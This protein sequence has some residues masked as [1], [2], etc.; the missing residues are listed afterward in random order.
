MN[1]MKLNTPFNIFCC[2]CKVQRGANRVQISLGAFSE[3]DHGWADRAADHTDTG[4]IVSFQ[5]SVALSTIADR[6][7][8]VRF[9]RECIAHGGKMR[10]VDPAIRVKLFLRSCLFLQFLH[11][12]CVFRSADRMEKR[13]RI[14]GRVCLEMR[15]GYTARPLLHRKGK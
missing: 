10:R 11:R 3:H 13:K 9:R 15:S 5:R 12:Q 6:N 7:I 2:R 1:G 4:S 8:T 14:A